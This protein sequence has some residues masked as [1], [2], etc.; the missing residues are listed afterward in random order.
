LWKW[1]GEEARCSE[2]KKVETKSG[3]RREVE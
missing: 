2:V 1:F 3:A